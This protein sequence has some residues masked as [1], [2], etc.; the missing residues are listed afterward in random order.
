[1]VAEYLAVW[2][3]DDVPSLNLIYKEWIVQ[4][5]WYETPAENVIVG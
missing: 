3:D 2:V 5:L 1:M 4:C